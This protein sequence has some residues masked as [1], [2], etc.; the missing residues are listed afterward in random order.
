MQ[1]NSVK[2]LCNLL[3]KDDKCKELINNEGIYSIHQCLHTGS[4]KYTLKYS[5]GALL[6]MTIL[7]NEDKQL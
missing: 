6:N 1:E 2:L 7:L 3:T 4:T 5:L